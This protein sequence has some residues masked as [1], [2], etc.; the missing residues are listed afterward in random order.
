MKATAAE[1]KEAVKKRTAGPSPK[2]HIT[3]KNAA[4]D[5]PRTLN[6]DDIAKDPAMTKVDK[7]KSTAGAS[8]KNN[9]AGKAATTDISNTPL[10]K[11]TPS[12]TLPPL[13]P[14]QPIRPPPS[15]SLAQTLPSQT[16]LPLPHPAPAPQQP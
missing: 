9:F 16:F 6:K 10:A 7:D 4:T 12:S 14:T 1:T 8:T 15:M 11:K 5:I 13:P 2:K 3:G